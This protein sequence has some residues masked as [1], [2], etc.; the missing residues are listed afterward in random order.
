MKKKLLIIFAVI[1]LCGCSSNATVSDKQAAQPQQTENAADAFHIGEEIYIKNSSK[2][3][4]LIV[5]TV[6]ETNQRNEFSDTNPKRVIVISYEYENIAGSSD[7]YIS[8]MDFKAYDADNNALS[9]YPALIDYP[10]AVG[11][12][13]KGTGQMAYGLDSDKNYIELEFYDNL[14]NSKSDC[15]IILEW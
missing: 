2:E 1:M 11:A 13:R 3:Y 14:F 4:K 9:T 5:K 6:E 12:G 7:L 8:E 15:K 10:Q